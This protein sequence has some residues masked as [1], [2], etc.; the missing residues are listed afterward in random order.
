[1]FLKLLFN[2]FGSQ[3]LYFHFKNYNKNG[4]INMMKNIWQRCKQVWTHCFF[5]ASYYVVSYY[6]FLNTDPYAD[7]NKQEPVAG[8]LKNSG[9]V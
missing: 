7:L 2:R 9:E 3:I 1:M 5:V 4:K 8:P 6:R